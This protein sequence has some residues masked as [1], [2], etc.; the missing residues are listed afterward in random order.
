M[1]YGLLAQ[2]LSFHVFP[3]DASRLRAALS[4][5]LSAAA[6]ASANPRE[7]GLFATLLAARG[8]RD[9]TSEH[10]W[11]LLMARLG[12]LCLQYIADETLNTK[13]PK[14]NGQEQE[15]G[16]EQ[17]MEMEKIV[18]AF[19]LISSRDE[20]RR[21]S[22]GVSS[23][24]ADKLCRRLLVSLALGRLCLSEKR[25]RA[26]STLGSTSPHTSNDFPKGGKGSGPPWSSDV[27]LVVRA[28]R[29]D[30]T[31]KWIRSPK[32]FHV[33]RMRWDR[34]VGTE[35][36]SIV[37]LASRSLCT[38]SLDAIAWEPRHNGSAQGERGAPASRGEGQ[39]DERETLG[40]FA[41]SMVT[42]PNLLEHPLSSLLMD[43][44][45]EAGGEVWWK[46]V[47]A[48]GETV[49]VERA[50]AGGTQASAMRRK[51]VAWTVANILRV[52]SRSRFRQPTLLAE[53]CLNQHV[54]DVDDVDDQQNER[55]G[56]GT[57]P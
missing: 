35:A 4:L 12:T 23:G 30:A 6:D 53:W 27:L 19:T 10:A 16:Q 52:S 3:R 15:Q 42:C 49:G 26:P 46:I 9:V 28:D 20:W 25:R 5:V 54:D 45:L 50:A 39:G 51:D 40:A 38:A 31:R 48:A 41:A 18:R 29:E 13:V 14:E 22:L 37:T 17:G 8:L 34:A 24:E 44:V 21:R 11:M 56:A 57:R 7:T 1:L 2:L 32:L 55:V 47:A 36:P 33:L 43:P